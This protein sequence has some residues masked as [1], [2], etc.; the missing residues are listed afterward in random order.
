MHARI[1]DCGSALT[2]GK[3]ASSINPILH[4]L[5]TQR[6][7]CLQQLLRTLIVLLRLERLF[8]IGVAPR[9]SNAPF[10]ASRS[11]TT[12]RPNRCT[13]YPSVDLRS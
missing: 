13:Q 4:L 8:G 10:I 1:Y 7:S 3:V 9:L 5:P 12:D 6:R 2:E 11:L